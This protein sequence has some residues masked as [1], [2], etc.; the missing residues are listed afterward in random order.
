MQFRV[1]IRSRRSNRLITVFAIGDAEQAF[2]VA[3]TLMRCPTWGAC[4]AQCTDISEKVVFQTSSDGSTSWA[5]YADT[6]EEAEPES[7]IRAV[8]LYGTVSQ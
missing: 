7:G 4:Y 1:E 8:P 2:N 6:T 3:S 5:E